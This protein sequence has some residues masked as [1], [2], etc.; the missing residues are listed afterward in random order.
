MV[1]R[2]SDGTDVG[3]AQEGKISDSNKKKTTFPFEETIH[4]LATVIDTKWSK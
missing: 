4:T 3:R 1:R 2:Y